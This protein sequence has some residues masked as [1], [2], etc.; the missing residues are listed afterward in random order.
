MSDID[1]KNTTTLEERKKQ[2]SVVL[3]KFYPYK[4]PVIIQKSKNDKNLPTIDKIKFLIP[5]DLQYASILT[6]LRNRM[7]PG[8]NDTTALFLMTES[9]VS[10][11]SYEKFNTIYN[12][13]KN[14]EDD[15]LYLYYC[16]EN[17]F[18]N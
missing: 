15:F 11:S 5:H 12:N 14:E 6:V 17:T 7:K 16:S 13:H 18:G 3:G 1:F 8:L 9:G 10:I 2:S 4:L